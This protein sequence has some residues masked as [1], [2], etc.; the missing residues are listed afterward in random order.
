MFQSLKGFAAVCAVVAAG[1]AGAATLTDRFTL[2]GEVERPGVY[3]LQRLKGFAP[4]QQTVSGRTFT[5][6]SLWELIGDAGLKPDPDPTVRNSSLSHYVIATGSDG[7]R[8]AFSLGGIEPRFGGAPTIVAYDE[9]G[10]GLGEDGFARIVAPLDNR[11]G[12]WVSN[13]E[14]LEVVNAAPGNPGGLGGPT[15]SFT[16][17]GVADPGTIDLAALQGF[18]PV[19]RDVSISGAAPVSF[20]GV[21]LWD[22]LDAK[23]LPLDPNVRNDVLRHLLVVTG[24][25]GYQVAFALGDLSPGFGDPLEL[26]MI[27]YGQ[28]GGDLG[29]RGFARLVI[30]GDPRGGRSAFNIAAM[31]VVP[32]MPG[33]APAPIPLPGG[34]ALSLGA[35]GA[36][37]AMRRRRP[38]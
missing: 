21:G 34:L 17:A 20:T 31:E 32:I 18:T 12:R 8:A 4:V 14:S 27:A 33:V 23:G 6:A 5:G 30:P 3:D 10:G 22:F 24:S 7:Y 38:S 25:D 13:L 11:R 2:F 35:L 15:S 28:D 9:N 29:D 16:L 1:Q 26:A 37:A 36:L 19:T